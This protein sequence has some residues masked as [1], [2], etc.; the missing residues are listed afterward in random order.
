[1]AWGFLVVCCKG[2]MDSSGNQWEISPTTLSCYSLPGGRDGTTEHN[3][4]ADDIN[5]YSMKERKYCDG[6]GFLRR[7]GGK[8]GMPESRA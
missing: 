2:S 4:R 3:N 5:S 7:E 1:M 6:D 8:E